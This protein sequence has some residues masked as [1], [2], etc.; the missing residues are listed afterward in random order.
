VL[1][2]E[3]KENFEDGVISDEKEQEFY[4]FSW[5]TA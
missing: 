4:A 1:S 5:V 3:Q 2:S